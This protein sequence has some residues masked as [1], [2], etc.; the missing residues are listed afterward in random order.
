M[1]LMHFLNNFCTENKKRF[2]LV[3]FILCV[4]F[5]AV[6]QAEQAYIVQNRE[7]IKVT[8]IVLLKNHV[9]KL[10]KTT[11]CYLAHH[12]S[13]RIGEVIGGR[14]RM[15]LSAPNKVGKVWVSPVSAVVL[16]F[17]NGP[18]LDYED[19]LDMKTGFIV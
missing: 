10:G 8:V 19:Y 18:L 3:I 13:H 5:N 2:I 6:T 4:I 15:S 12:L 16:Q 1:S 14:G 9:P 7:S 11:S 17:H